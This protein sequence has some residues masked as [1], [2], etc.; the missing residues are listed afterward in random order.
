MTGGWRETSWQGDAHDSAK[1][2]SLSRPVA[3][4]ANMLGGV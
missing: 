2:L 1:S 3:N 4:A